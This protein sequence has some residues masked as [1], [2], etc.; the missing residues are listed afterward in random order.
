[1]RFYF[2]KSVSH[3]R[4]I[5][6]KKETHFEVVKSD[7]DHVHKITGVSVDP[8]SDKFNIEEHII[9]KNKDT[10]QNKYRVFKIKSS[11][12]N[13]LLKESKNMKKIEID[14]NDKSNLKIQG[15]IQPIKIKKSSKTA[16]KVEKKKKD[17][18]KR[19]DIEKK[20]DVEKKKSE[21]KEKKILLDLTKN[22]IKVEKSKEKKKSKSK[23]KSDLLKK[24]AIDIN[25]KK[26]KSQKVD[27]KVD[28]KIK[29]K[30]PLEVKKK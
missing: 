25:V 13:T 9:K 19:K 22:T 15:K 23:S 16:I 5:N 6:G 3:T 1:M 18:E 10:L 28:T 4:D 20:K 30:I 29:K 7:G 11:N 26:S 17:V 2:Q 12:L 24:V 14:N 27:T 8:N 21:K